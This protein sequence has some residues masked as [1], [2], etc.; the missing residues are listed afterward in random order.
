MIAG[1]VNAR[2]RH[3]LVTFNACL[4]RREINITEF[5]CPTCL[6]FQNELDIVDFSM[7]MTIIQ[8]H[9]D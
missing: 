2:Q 1:N 7:C 3:L 9:Q 5:P 8:I 6:E 4:K